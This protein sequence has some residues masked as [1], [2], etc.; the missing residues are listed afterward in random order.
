[1]S[2]PAQFPGLDAVQLPARPLHLAIG[3]FDGV[4]L[5][6]QAVIESAVHSARRSGGLAGVLTFWPHPSA[7]FRPAERTRMLMSPEMKARVLRRLGV[8]VIIAQPFTAEFARIPAEEFLPYLRARLPGLAG[9]YVGENWR[10]G[11]GRRGDVRLLLASAARH[12]APV[13][14]VP[15]LI[16]DGAPISSTRIRDCLATGDVEAA[17]RF[18]G[19]AYFAEGV[20][21]PGARLGRT[22]GFPTLNVPW[23][24]E[25]TPRYGVYVVRVAGE[26]ADGPRPA[27]ANYGVRPTVAA[28]GGPLLEAHVLGD[29]PFGA[30]MRVTVEWLKFLRPEQ[31]FSGPDELRAQIG[32]DRAAAEAWFRESPAAHS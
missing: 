2:V 29:C 14:S 5:G 31:K 1:V 3:M 10:F 22:L 21:T 4:H 27:V 32:R 16:C 7:L 18:L 9:V 11:A 15:R 24:P 26:A 28:G 13:V 23:Q 8:D 19:Y 20:V 25:L 12:Q 6:H 17:N 30:G